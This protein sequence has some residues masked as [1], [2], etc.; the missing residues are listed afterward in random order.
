MKK[1]FLSFAALALVASVYS[2]RETNEEKAEDNM[3]QMA[4]DMEDAAEDTGDAMENAAEE[5]G[6]AMDL[7]LIHI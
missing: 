7:S 4:D 2:C 5:T 6:E 1:V 3:E